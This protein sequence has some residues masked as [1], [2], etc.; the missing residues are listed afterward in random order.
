[1]DFSRRKKKKN[2]D[3]R[4]TDIQTQWTE[5]RQKMTHKEVGAD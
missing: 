5:I 2:K 4:K 1:M 3:K